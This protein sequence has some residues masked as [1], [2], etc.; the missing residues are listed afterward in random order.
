MSQAVADLP[1]DVESLR[2]IIAAQAVELAEAARRLH[3][4]DTLIEKFKAQLAALRWARF[5]A[6]ARK[7]IT[8][9]NRI[10]QNAPRFVGDKAFLS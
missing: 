5:N 9:P 7:P 10:F 3:T 2:A 4:R 8:P 6:A 1:D